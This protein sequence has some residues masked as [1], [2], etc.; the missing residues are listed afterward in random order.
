M[1]ADNILPDFEFIRSFLFENKMKFNEIAVK[2]YKSLCAY[3]TIFRLL[4]NGPCSFDFIIYTIKE[5]NDI[6]NYKYDL[7]IH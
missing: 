1:Q 4:H 7:R 6:K 5:I 3:I 2:H